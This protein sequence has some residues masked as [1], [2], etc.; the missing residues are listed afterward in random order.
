MKAV[1]PAAPAPLPV[2]PLARADGRPGNRVPAAAPFLSV[3]IVNYR[4]WE[5][6]A[7]LV[8]QLRAGGAVR[9][10]A[11][12]V[13]VVDNGS[14]RHPLAG[15]LRRAEGVSLRR[16]GR[17]R[18]FARAVNEGVRLSRGRWTLLL[19]PDV[20]VDEGFLDGV[21]DLAERL[22]GEPRAGVVGL[23]VRND[24]GSRQPS[25]G[26]F[27]TLAGTL[28][29]LLLP[30][31]RRKC[32]FYSPREG[33][34]VPWATGCCL[35]VRRRLL[36]ELGGLD[37]DFFLYYEDVDLCRRAG[38]RGW[39]VRYEPA[40]AAVH[41]RPLHRRAVGP[42]L[43]LLTR[44]ALL[45]YALKHWP[46]WQG[47]LLARLIGAEAWLKRWRAAWRGDADGVR[48]FEELGRLADEMRTGRHDVAR[49]RLERVV[50]R[51]ERTDD[52]FSDAS[53]KRRTRNASAKRR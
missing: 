2:V 41:H 34:S 33:S 37:P 18:G 39:E 10:G 11:A 49:H 24:D 12:E 4:G 46:H 5:D 44:H 47:R 50:W 16:W 8:G 13:M 20:T 36:D 26:P 7:R 6:T 45:T 25:T 38:E 15:R 31:A 52:R 14:P 19:N 28:W 51:W 1:A 17:N 22:E 42:H 21:L 35:L 48:V 53:Q 29:R 9:S 32:H 23:G 30:R 43:R 27:P 40:P 3:V